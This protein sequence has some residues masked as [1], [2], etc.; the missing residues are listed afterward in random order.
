MESITPKRCATMLNQA[1][2]AV[3]FTGAGI[4][5]A[6]GI[7]DFRGPN[8]LYATGQYDADKVFEISHFHR[9]PELFYHFS[10]DFL[11]A[12]QKISPTFTHQFLAKL[13]ARDQLSGI[14]TQNID[15]LHHLAGSKTVAE[16][17]GSY[18]SAA[19][20]QCNNYQVER[21]TV[22][23]WKKQI[24]ESKR[25]PVVLC[26]ECQGVVKPHVVFFGEPVRDMDLAR[27]L[28][29]ATDLLL[30]LGSSLTVYPAAF[31]PRMT[32]APVIVVNQGPA[33]LE[34]GANRFFADSDLDDFFIKVDEYI[35]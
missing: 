29:A 1:R 10:R 17:H 25:T 26:P 6:A 5:T 13:E 31:L 33:R 2:R 12:I 28:I 22:E 24:A 4:S 23:W 21:L 19:C 8:G 16:L 11:K 9:H 27:N 14:I 30:V 34:P 35:A 3:A 15:A 32:D 18:W 20:Q 7:P